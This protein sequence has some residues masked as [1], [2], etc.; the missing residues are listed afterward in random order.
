[1]LRATCDDAMRVWIDGVLQTQ[2]PGVNDWTKVM[3]YQYSDCTQL[4]AIECTDKHYVVIGLL[5]DTSTGIVSDGTWKCTRTY[6]AGWEKVGFNDG[7]WSGADVYG[8][9]PTYPWNYAI[10]IISG[11][12]NW[13]GSGSNWDVRPP[14]IYCRKNLC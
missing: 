7:G 14:V 1:M 10:P 13:I 3:E 9:N 5:A 8:P 2:T 12:A 11:A 4:I 6:Y